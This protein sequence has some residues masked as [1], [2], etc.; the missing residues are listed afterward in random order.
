LDS[1]DFRRWSHRA[2][3]WSADYLADLGDRPVRAQVEPGQIYRQI[4]DAPPERGEPMEA[5]FADLDEIILPGIT[6]WQH[7]R[8]F[9]YFP[10]TASPP[11]MVAEQLTAAIAAQ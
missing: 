8:F 11:S 6:H 3:D 5:I 1:Q 10:A 7:P 4:P 9:A 2:A